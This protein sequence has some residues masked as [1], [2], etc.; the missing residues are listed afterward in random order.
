MTLVELLVVVGIISILI[1]VSATALVGSSSAKITNAANLLADELELARQNA[2]ARNERVE[3]R[4]FQLPDSMSDQTGPPS[5]FRG[6]QAYRIDDNQ[7]ALPLRKLVSLPEG[8]A[9]ATNNG[10]STLLQAKNPPEYVTGTTA[11]KKAGAYSPTSYNYYAFRFKPDGSTDLSPIAQSWH[12]TVALKA[13][14]ADGPAG[15]PANFCTIQIDPQ[16]GRTRL[17]QPN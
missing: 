5:V 17:Y 7:G 4:F 15:L 13:A 12:V 9:M 1:G 6:F 8:V 14:K 2:I 10:V 3:V 16:S 11:G